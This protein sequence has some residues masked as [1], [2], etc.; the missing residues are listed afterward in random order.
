LVASSSNGS[1][2]A[3]ARIENSTMLIPKR[4]GIR[5]SVCRSAYFGKSIRSEVWK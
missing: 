1:P 3:A 2:G 4:M 5:R